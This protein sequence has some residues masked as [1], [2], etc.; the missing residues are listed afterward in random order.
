[1]MGIAVGLLLLARCEATSDDADLADARCVTAGATST[2]S[3]VSAM[4]AF[5]M[6]RLSA[7]HPGRTWPVVFSAAYRP[8]RRPKEA[9]RDCLGQ[10]NSQTESQGGLSVTG[11]GAKAVTTN[12]E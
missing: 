8:T 3:V 6:G 4:T 10:W 9:L 5:H 7:R 12:L 1:M 2:D 11:P